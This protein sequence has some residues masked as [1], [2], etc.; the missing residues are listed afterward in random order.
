MK[1]PKVQAITVI[2]IMVGAI[3][4]I[5]FAQIVNGETTENNV[6]PAKI[7]DTVQKSDVETTVTAPEGAQAVENKKTY[8]DSSS[9]PNQRVETPV[10]QESA[11][12]P[13][14]QAPVVA[15]KPETYVN[16]VGQCPFYEMG[17]EKGCVPPSDIECNA[18]WSVCTKK[19]E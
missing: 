13:F 9:T 3:L 14:T 10:P 19:G 4:V 6:K 11:H 7:N 16:T 12:V 8:V 1:N 15:G 5:G 2:A 17:G 18:D